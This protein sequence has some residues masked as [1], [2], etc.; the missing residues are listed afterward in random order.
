MFFK[1]GLRSILLFCIIVLMPI[2]SINAFSNP[3]MLWYSQPAREW[4]E[5]LP[6]GNGRLG[7]MVFGAIDSEHI[8]LNENTLWSGKQNTFDRVGAYHN[9]PKVRQLLFEGQYTEAEKIIRQEFYGER[10]LYNYQTLGDLFLNFKKHG[11]VTNYRRTLDI[12]KAVVAIQYT[13]GD[14]IFTREVFAS[15][16]Y[17]SDMQ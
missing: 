15:H 14:A 5:S 3:L 10:P 1:I 9:L 8:Q 2:F 11:D 13:E 12:D 4:T 7:A 6:V 17:S 16:N